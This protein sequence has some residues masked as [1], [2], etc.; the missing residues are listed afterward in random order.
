M[1]HSNAALLATLGWGTAFEGYSLTNLL[2][3]RRGRGV[4][5]VLL[6][7]RFVGRFHLLQLRL[8]LRSEHL[9]ELIVKLG[10]CHRQVDFD[11]RPL[12]G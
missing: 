3:W 9:V 8:L 2:F 4:L 11:L 1:P 10:L 6:H 7:V 5:H 12:R